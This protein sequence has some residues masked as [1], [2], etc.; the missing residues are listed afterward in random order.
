MDLIWFS[1]NKLIHEAVTLASDKIQLQLSSLVSRHFSAW[2]DAAL[3]S[4]SISPLY[5]SFKANF[6]VAV[7]TAAVISDSIGA[8][9]F[10]ATSKLELMPSWE[11]LLQLF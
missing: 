9:I 4:L 7:S 5:G 10:A 6:N 11:K 2:K 3:P 1:R 8:I